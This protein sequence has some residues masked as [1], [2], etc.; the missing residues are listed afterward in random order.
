MQSEETEESVKRLIDS[1]AYHE[2]EKSKERK[3]QAEQ[4]SKDEVSQA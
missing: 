2:F 3:I 1:A 4:E